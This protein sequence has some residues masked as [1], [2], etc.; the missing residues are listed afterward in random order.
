LLDQSIDRSLL[1][2]RAA[3][4]HGALAAFVDPT[5]SVPAELHEDWQ[6]TLQDVEA[7]GA[8]R[9]VQL[10]HIH[11]NFDPQRH[12]GFLYLENEQAAERVLA[13]TMQIAAREALHD[14]GP[15]HRDRC[16]CGWILNAPPPQLLKPALTQLARVHKPDGAPW[17]LRYWDPRVT[18]QLPR[19]LTPL[20]LQLA[21]QAMGQWWTISPLNQLICTSHLPVPVKSDTVAAGAANAQTLPLRFDRVEWALLERVGVVNTVLRMA[22]EWDVL[23][24]ET[25]ARRVDE[26]VQRC[27]ARGFDSEQDALI[28]SACGLTSH[29]R[30]DEH[31]AVDEALR[32]AAQ[33]GQSLQAALSR[34]EETFWSDL[35]A[36]RWQV[37]PTKD[38]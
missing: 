12:P 7:S 23:P 6:K 15:E 24:T 14:Y 35:A 4:G 30:F 19:V 26:L 1:A 33:H 37:E 2:L 17:Y 22:W 5:L 18:W 32:Q 28:F 8:A 9:W 20:Q 10:G 25:S 31:P 36:E 27:H 11:D 21:H 13:L 3:A 29:A 16:L 38:G 34:F